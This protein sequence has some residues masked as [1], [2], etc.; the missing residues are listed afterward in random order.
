M[1]PLALRVVRRFGLRE[2]LAPLPRFVTGRTSIPDG[3][4]VQFSHDAGPRNFT[5][6]LASVLGCSAQTVG[7]ATAATPRG[8]RASRPAPSWSVALMKASRMGW[9]AKALRVEV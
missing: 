8:L 7:E 9:K 1:V 5:L 2:N 4:E 6:V 3:D